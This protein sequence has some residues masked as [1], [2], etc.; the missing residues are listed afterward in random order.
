MKAT[1]NMI[2]WSKKITNIM[3][4]CDMFG[5]WRVMWEESFFSIIY[6][7]NIWFKDVEKIIPVIVEAYKQQ[8]QIVSF[9]HLQN[10]SYEDTIIKNNNKIKPYI[11]KKVKTISNWRT[12]FLLSEFTKKILEN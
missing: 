2:S 6:K 8:W 3:S 4:S 9:L 5:R 12:W 1:F 11:N 10:I 7:K